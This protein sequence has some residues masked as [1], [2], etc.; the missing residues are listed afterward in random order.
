MRK[1]F[2]FGNELVKGDSM[3][4]QLCDCMDC[5]GFK[6]VKCCSLDE[7]LD[8]AKNSG[9]E[10][11][12]MDVVKGLKRPMLIDDVSNLRTKNIISL[13]DFDLA[14]FLKLMEKAGMIRKLL[15][16]GVPS[17]GDAS[18]IRGDVEKLL[19]QEFPEAEETGD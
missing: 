7:L 2:C 19:R 5:R 14:F 11:I 10:L 3:A 18:S 17:E 8:H 1:V 6:F 16:I 13:H 4:K 15:I 12:I 9:N